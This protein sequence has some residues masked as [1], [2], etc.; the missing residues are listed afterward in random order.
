MP[1]NEI[2]GCFP[3]SLLVTLET[4]KALRYSKLY[5]LGKALILVVTELLLRNLRHH[6]MKIRIYIYIYRA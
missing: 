2:P 4:P 3:G 6:S 5:K 1:G